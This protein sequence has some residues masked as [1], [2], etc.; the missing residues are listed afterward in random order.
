MGVEIVTAERYIITK[1]RSNV[2]EFGG[3]LK[4]PTTQA[5][6][7][8]H[9]FWLGG[10]REIITQGPVGHVISIS[11]HFVGICNVLQE[12]GITLNNAN[13][14]SLNLKPLQIW[15]QLA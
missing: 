8:G 11:P 2:I 13:L 12:I 4:A 1:C 7:P 14:L 3:F 15:E 9:F 5:S 6:S 10:G